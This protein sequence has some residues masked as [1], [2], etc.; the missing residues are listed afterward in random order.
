MFA[1]EETRRAGLYFDPSQTSYLSA[2]EER[3]KEEQRAARAK[4][5]G[6]SGPP[7]KSRGLLKK[8]GGL[9]IIVVSFFLPPL[10]VFFLPDDSV[11][12]NCRL[13]YQ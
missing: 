3:A 5:R 13:N 8:E 6:E 11:H 10:L 12:Y 7:S 4:S 9:D 1:D 2:K